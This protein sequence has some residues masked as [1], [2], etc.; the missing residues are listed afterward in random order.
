MYGASASI[1]GCEDEEKEDE[2]SFE[3][4]ELVDRGITS[5]TVEHR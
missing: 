5:S 3:V 1:T 4:G 2:A